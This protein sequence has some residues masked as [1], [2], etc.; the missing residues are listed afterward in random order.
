VFEIFNFEKAAHLVGR[1]PNA[2]A[3]NL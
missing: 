2:A 1:K 3:R